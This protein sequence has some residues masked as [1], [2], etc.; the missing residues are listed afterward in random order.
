MNRRYDFFKPFSFAVDL[1]VLVVGFFV[2]HRIRL[3]QWDISAYGGGLEPVVAVSVAV[4]SVSLFLS[5]IYRTHPRDMHLKTV[6]TAG[7][8]LTAGWAVSVLIMFLI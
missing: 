7:I 4:Y 8:A 5:G 6:W 3:G 1:V 2:A